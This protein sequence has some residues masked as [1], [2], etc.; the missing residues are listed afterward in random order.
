MNSKSIQYTPANANKTEAKGKQKLIDSHAKSSISSNSIYTFAHSCQLIHIFDCD[1]ASMKN[2]YLQNFYWFLLSISVRFKWHT[3]FSIG[4][5]SNHQSLMAFSSVHLIY[6]KLN[7]WLLTRISIDE[8]T[9]RRSKMF[10]QCDEH[11]KILFLWDQ[12]SNRD[13]NS[14]DIQL[15]ICNLALLQ[16]S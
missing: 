2:F 10:I 14:C 9:I 3:L 11:R 1:S 16:T 12:H 13:Q 8:F 15:S 5:W 6:G 4:N 7:Q